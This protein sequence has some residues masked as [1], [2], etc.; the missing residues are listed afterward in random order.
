MFRTLLVVGEHVDGNTVSTGNTGNARR[1]VRGAFLRPPWA[2]K[3]PPAGFGLREASPADVSPFGPLHAEILPNQISIL[4][5]GTRKCTNVGEAASVANVTISA[6]DRR[7]FLRVNSLM[8]DLRSSGVQKACLRYCPQV[9]LSVIVMNPR[10]NYRPSGFK[11]RRGDN[12]A[13]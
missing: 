1:R 12:S 8:A 3:T 2:L 13:K 4:I 9:G 11:S 10:R 7:M 5:F 6:G